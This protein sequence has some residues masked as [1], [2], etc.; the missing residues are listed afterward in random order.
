MCVALIG[1]MER[2]ERHY[3]EEA[4]KLG[5]SLKVFNRPRAGMKSQVVNADAVVVFTNKVS[6][7]AK[8]EAKGLAEA[9]NIPVMMCHSCGVCSLRDCLDCLKGKT[10]CRR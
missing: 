6:H 2:L 5:I 1:G 10:G 8:R 7:R 4:E 3:V 9:R